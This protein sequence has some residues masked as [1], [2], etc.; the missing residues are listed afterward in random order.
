M[1]RTRLLAT[2]VLLVLAVSFLSGFGHD[3][4]FWAQ[5]GRDPEHT[6]MVE[7]SGQP[8]NRKL[9]DIIY[10]PF[11][12]QE[13]LANLGV[14]GVSVLTAHY[15]STLIDGNSFYM[16]QKTGTY[17]DCHPVTAWGS[18]GACGPNTW[19]LM[20][21][22]VA[23]YDWVNDLAVRQ[24]VV[25]TDW[26]PEPNDTNFLQGYTGLSGWEPVFHPAL[27]NGYLYAPGASGT[28]WK[29]NLQNGE[30]AAH[31]NPFAGMTLNP[32]M[33]FVAGPL[34]VDPNGDIYYNAIE[35]SPHGNPWQENDVV[36][37][38]LVKVRPD[39]TSAVVTFATLVPNAPR[40]NSLD[41][42]GTFFS[43]G[44]NGA[45]LPWPP[46][47]TSVPPTLPCGSQRPPLNVAPAIA[48]DGTI[49]TASVA[50]FDS[51]VA[52]LVAVNPDLTPKWAVTLQHRMNDGCGVLLPIAPQGDTTMPNS[53]RFGTTPGV[54]PVTNAKGS[55]YVYDYA[56]SSPTVLPDSSILMGV[57]D[58]YDY[59]RGHLLHFDTQGNYINAFNFGWD[60]TPAVYSHDGTYSIVTKDNH[61]G[62]EAYCYFQN[63][64]VCTPIPEGPYYLSQINA[65]LQLEWSFQNTS[66]DQNHPNGYE[67]CVNAPVIDGQGTVYASSEDGSL[68][69]VPQGHHGVFT[70]PLQK[71]FLLEALGAAYTPL[72]IGEDG[73]EY[74]QND[75]H[76]FVLGK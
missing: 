29:V 60:T 5:W 16:V 7:I 46:T 70:K 73:K 26:K 28:L 11:V 19:N 64:P 18:G 47:P 13:K 44:D 45:S 69:A 53:C 74:S 6:G 21:W 24:W 34:T 42:P 23:R 15:Q 50:H 10:D 63:N 66:T 25:P 2:L 57:Y 27:A 20:Q 52:Y 38:W 65:D 43:L 36:S 1:P 14:D 12:N 59:G 40:G 4:V 72:S 32:G 75:G 61:Y 30:A 35:L 8:F 49:Y 62:G 51:M 39:D 67:W 41:C 33:I 68:Y 17:L 37:G 54:D 58:D 9:A 48:P 55:G 31:I 71:M 22:N 56:S 76:L 3:G